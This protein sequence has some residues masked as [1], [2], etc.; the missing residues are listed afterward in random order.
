MDTRFDSFERKVNSVLEL[1]D[2]LRDENRTLR[3]QLAAL[4]G[5]NQ[6]LTHTINTSRERLEALLAQLP[7]A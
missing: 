4:E 7:E 2:S 6:R 3:T 5:T 1:V